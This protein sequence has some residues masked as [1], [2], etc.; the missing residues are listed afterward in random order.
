MTAPIRWA[1]DHLPIIGQN[2]ICTLA[3]QLRNWQRYDK[4]YVARCE[5]FRASAGWDLPTWER[6]QFQELR[7]LHAYC[8]KKVPYYQQNLG[9]LVRNGGLRGLD[10]WRQV[11]PLTKD[12]A[13]SAGDR[14]ISRD[15]RLHRLMVSQSG[16]STGM[17]LRCYHDAD[18]LR[19]VY[20]YFWATQ[21]P[22][23]SRRDRYA[24]FQ[25]LQ[26][27]PPGQSGGPYWRMNYAMKQRLYSIFHLS[28]KTVRVY[29][30]DLDRFQPIYLAG[31]ANSL[32]LLATLIEE[33]GLRPLHAPRAVFTTSEQLLPTCRETIERVFRTRVWDAYSQDET[34]GSITQYE[35]GYY[36]YDRAY[37][38]MEFEDIEVLPNGRRCAEI[39]CTGFFNRAWPLLRY[40]PGDLVEYE[41]AE[42]CPGC[43]RA[44]PIIHGIRGRT[45][46]VLLLPSGRRFPHIS[47]IV[48]DLKGVR[49]LQLI[50]RAINQIT[51]R[52]VPSE[53]F[54]GDADL[55]GIVRAFQAAVNEPIQWET[56]RVSEI[57]RT[58]G[59]KFL[60][61]V[62]CLRG[63]GYPEAFAADRSVS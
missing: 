2:F 61:I 50:Q 19:R 4:E 13:R 9:A 8:L 26:I 29:L 15:F 31:Y 45:G 30:A 33:C 46:D 55:E 6:Y 10:D 21:R 1:Y 16:G 23:V 51:I 40:R 41:P 20:A 5:F 58:L 54:R 60:S 48:K 17:P 39:I 47:L 34:C 22:G 36:H 44:G 11:P 59:G 57:P 62:S 12:D 28:E 37:G 56:E 53:S 27:I 24:T 38:F 63:R 18:A 42:R 43:G 3:G 7:E 25:G 52:F 14:L 49:Q 35:C 32:Y